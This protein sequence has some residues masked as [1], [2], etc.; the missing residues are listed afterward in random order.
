MDTANSGFKHGTLLSHMGVWKHIIDAKIPWAI[1]WED[2]VLFHKDWATLAPAYFEGTP[3]DYDLLYMGHHCGCGRP[4]QILKVP[5]YC[6]HAMVVSLNGAK[7]IYERFLTEPN[8]VR[9]IDCLI[10]HFMM[11]ALTE[12]KAFCN[13]YAWNAEMYPDET[14]SKHPQHAHKDVGLVFQEYVQERTHH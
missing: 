11:Q 13:W 3:K 9:T 7:T 2:D 6:S 8:G 14:A 1:I 10:N 4:F 5:V 12:N